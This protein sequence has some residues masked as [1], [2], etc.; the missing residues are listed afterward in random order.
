MPVLKDFHDDSIQEYAY[1][2]DESRRLLTE[3]GY[4][5]DGNG[6][7][8]LTF[9]MIYSLQDPVTTQWAALVRDSTAKAGITIK[10]QGVERNTYLAM[11]DEGDFDIYAG[12]FAIM[13]DPA[14]NMSLAYLPK[15]AINYT[16]VDDPELNSLIDRARVTF[17]QE[18]QIPIMREAAK[19]V[20]DNVYDNIMYTQN[21]FVAY[22]ADWSGFVVKPSELLSIVHPLSVA[23]TTKATG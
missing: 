13:D 9:R 10:L 12:N 22:R 14:T 2:P 17:E 7:F 15:G 8:P 1:D 5:E 20:R 16:H 18:D 19:L 3:A 6:R 4:K 21:L 23:A 11:T